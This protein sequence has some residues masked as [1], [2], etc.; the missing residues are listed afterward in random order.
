MEVEED[1]DDCKISYILRRYHRKIFRRQ[2]DM[3]IEAFTQQFQNPESVA[4]GNSQKFFF[5]VYNHL[6]QNN[7]SI[8]LLLGS[9]QQLFLP[10]KKTSSLTDLHKIQDHLLTQQQFYFHRFFKFLKNNI[11]YVFDRETEFFHVS[12]LQKYFPNPSLKNYQMVRNVN[13]D[14]ICASTEE[15]LVIFLFVIVLAQLC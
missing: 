5:S 14:W 7:S 2:V 3:Q 15:L 10:V 13:T 9:R 6:S 1:I 4:E 8:F 12:C 11:V